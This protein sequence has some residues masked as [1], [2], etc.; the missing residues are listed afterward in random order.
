MS[1]LHPSDY[2]LKGIIVK[3]YSLEEK[4]KALGKENAAKLDED[5]FD[6]MIEGKIYLSPAGTL[7][8]VYR[9]EEVI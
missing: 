9:E 6:I 5:L 8:P 4:A 2:S 7:I 3:K 1:A